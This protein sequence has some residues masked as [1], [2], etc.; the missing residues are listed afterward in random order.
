M[1]E[2]SDK[3]LQRAAHYGMRMSEK[4]LGVFEKR[5]ENDGKDAIS[6]ATL[7]G[8]YQFKE[9][10]EAA[11]SSLAH[12]TWFIE[13]MPNREISA[14]PLGRSF[15]DGIEL[16]TL[17][18]LWKK[19]LELYPL[20]RNV[21]YNAVRFFSRAG[22]SIGEPVLKGLLQEF[23]SDLFL[24]KGL[25]Q[26]LKDLP[27]RSHEALDLAEEIMALDSS[28]LDQNKQ[29]MLAMDL[30]NYERAEKYCLAQLE[31]LNQRYQDK[32]NFDAYTKSSINLAHT[33]LGLIALERNE[34]AKAKEHLFKSLEFNDPKGFIPSLDLAKALAAIGDK[35][36]A[37]EYLDRC[38]QAGLKGNQRRKYLRYKMQ[39]SDIDFSQ[40]VVGMPPGDFE[41]LQFEFNECENQLFFVIGA[42]SWNKFTEEQK[43]A[44]NKV[45]VTGEVFYLVG[46][47]DHH[48]PIE[49]FGSNEIDC[50]KL[51]D[52]LEQ[53][54]FTT[55]DLEQISDAVKFKPYELWRQD[56]NGNQALIEVLPC[57]A[58]ANAKV[59]MYTDR[60]HKQMYWCKPSD[61]GSNK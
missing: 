1:T 10:G 38:D 53:L 26:I 24:M 32:S 18:Q 42:D 25:Y 21:R 9:I 35:Q 44:N 46:N 57:R 5:L 45:E 6:R 50:E 22:Q 43:S 41:D 4:E 55:K 39:N 60:G 28:F 61:K 2:Y 3:D 51:N 12:L 59:K 31:F 23:P 13:N 20:D 52:L 47:A 37:V 58:D 29:I 16:Q 33:M 19:Q 14:F 54:G 48:G 15:S 27:D 11:T 56:D 40:K 49:V 17:C 8:F 30:A 7:L 34:Q 36:S